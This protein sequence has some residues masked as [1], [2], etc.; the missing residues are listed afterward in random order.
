MNICKPTAWFMNNTNPVWHWC[1]SVSS[2]AQSCPTLCNPMNH[3]TP[4][5]PVHH[6][7]L[8]FIQ[9]HFHRIGDAIQPSHPLS[10]PSP[11]APKSLPASGSFPMSKLFTWASQSIGVSASASVLPPN[12]QNGLPLGWTGWIFLQSKGLSR[13]FSNTIVQSINSLVLS[14]LHST[15]LTSICD[16]WKNRSLD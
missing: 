14:F 12:I 11:P 10:S 8:E 9:T 2:V 15:T 13:V 3:S 16:H 7:L 4:D 5:L 1:Q 6:Q